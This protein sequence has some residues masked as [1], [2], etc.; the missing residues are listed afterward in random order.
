MS[1]LSHRRRLEGHR[2]SMLVTW[3]GV[4]DAFRMQAEEFKIQALCRFVQVL[5]EAMKLHFSCQAMVTELLPLDDCRWQAMLAHERWCYAVREK[6]CA[7]TVWNGCTFCVWEA[8]CRKWN[9]SLY[10]CTLML[11][12]HSICA[13]GDGKRWRFKIYYCLPF[14]ILLNTY[15]LQHIQHGM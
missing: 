12:T 10:Y 4:P 2:G 15:F 7:T 11:H 14:L 6:C 5:R 8:G 13:A 9:F 1:C 3:L